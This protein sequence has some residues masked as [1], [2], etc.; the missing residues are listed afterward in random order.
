MRGIKVFNNIT[1]ILPIL[2]CFL[3]GPAWGEDRISVILSDSEAA[4]SLPVAA[5]IREVNR[6]VKIYNLQGD[7]DNA[8]LIMKS[9]FESDSRLILA[10][11]AK[12]AFIAKTWTKERQEIVVIFAMV[13]NWERYNLTA[14]QDNIA[15]IAADVSLGTQFANLALFAPQVSRVGVVYSKQY[16]EA[17]IIKARKEAAKLGLELVA[18]AVDRPDDF[19]RAFRSMSDKVDA[20]LLFPDPV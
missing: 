16:S 17:K 10:L 5:F 4:Y 15:G 20:F 13:L 2:L 19:K 8:P 6:P 7:I 12:A 18:E 9:I 14:D 3:A 11:G 1:I